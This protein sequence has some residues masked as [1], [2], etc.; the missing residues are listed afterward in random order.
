LPQI[1][2]E[3]RLQA[4]KKASALKCLGDFL[5]YLAK[6]PKAGEKLEKEKNCKSC[7]YYKFCQYILKKALD[8]EHPR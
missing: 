8:Y 6:D 7:D 1:G 2:D 3:K 4:E 5:E